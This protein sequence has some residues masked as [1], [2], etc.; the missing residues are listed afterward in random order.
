MIS[1]PLDQKSCASPE[2]WILERSLKQS[3]PAVKMFFFRSK[4]ITPTGM[5]LITITDSPRRVDPG[6]G[7]ESAIGGMPGA[8]RIFAQRK[9]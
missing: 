5:P 2:M 1:Y 3:D 6:F 9:G 7:F 8:F 4:V